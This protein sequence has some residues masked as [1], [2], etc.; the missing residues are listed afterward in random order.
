M[1]HL[2]ITDF[3]EPQPKDIA[4]SESDEFFKKDSVQMQ[5]S[6][7]LDEVEPCCNLLKTSKNFTS[8][9]EISSSNSSINSVVHE[10]NLDL[11]C[12]DPDTPIKHKGWRSPRDPQP[13]KVRALTKQFE[14]MII[15]K[16]GG[17]ESASTPDLTSE[18]VFK[19]PQKY[20]SEETLDNRLSEYERLEILKLLHDWSL[21]GSRSESTF[22]FNS[23]DRKKVY[24]V[25]FL[26]DVDLS[27]KFKCP[28]KHHFSETNV[29]KPLDKDDF[30]H[31]CKYRNCIFNKKFLMCGTKLK[32]GKNLEDTN[33]KLCG[34]NRRHSE[35]ILTNKKEDGQRR[36]SYENCGRNSLNKKPCKFPEAYIIT[37]RNNSQRKTLSDINKENGI[38]KPNAK[39]IFFHKKCWKSCS[40]IKCRTVRKCCRNARQSCP[41]YKNSCETPNKIQNVSNSTED[42]S[43]KC[44]TKKKVVFSNCNA[45]SKELIN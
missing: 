6:V 18:N 40:D 16:N 38:S 15:D 32:T 2:Q 14:K 13:G 8:L 30:L 11:S 28:S 39:I 24:D 22:V 41:I 9:Q 34:T 21:Q 33:E 1:F 23:K 7:S 20:Y 42:I 31:S 5:K 3:S 27:P 44:D 29:N 19:L 37:K 25:K 4:L 17:R 43:D 10:S 35:V 45:I 12:M 26:S 36:A